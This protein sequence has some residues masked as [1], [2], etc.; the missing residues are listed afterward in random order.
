MQ[1]NICSVL[2][3][4]AGVLV[5]HPFDTVKVGFSCPISYLLACTFVAWT[6]FFPLND[7]RII[8]EVY[9]R[10]LGA[11]KTKQNNRWN[12]Q[13]KLPSPSISVFLV[14]QWVVC[15]PPSPP[16]SR[17]TLHA[18]KKK[19]RQTKSCFGKSGEIGELSRRCFCA[20][21]V[22]HVNVALHA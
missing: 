10:V 13:H 21:V 18:T 6:F 3:G 2:T 5:G 4:A 1:P 19:K 8:F 11:L 12:L 15:I 9:W 16:P 14:A 17:W 20:H 22:F 7:C